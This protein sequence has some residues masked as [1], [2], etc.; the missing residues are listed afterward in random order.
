V[1]G[2]YAMSAAVKRIATDAEQTEAAYQRQI[3]RL[4]Q[5]RDEARAQEL[6][7]RKLAAEVISLFAEKGHPG[8]PCL[9]TGWVAEATVVRWHQ[10]YREAS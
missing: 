6:K 1:K 4:T 8:H 2:K 9:R 5:E 10:T 3:V 7:L